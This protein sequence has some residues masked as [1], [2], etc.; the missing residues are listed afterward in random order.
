MAGAAVI[1]VYSGSPS[2]QPAAPPAPARRVVESSAPPSCTRCA[3]SKMP[4]TDR[5]NATPPNVRRARCSWSSR[6]RISTTAALTSSTGRISPGLPNRSR[7]TVLTKEPTGPPAP[8]QEPTAQIRPTAIRPSATPS[9][10]C[11]GSMSDAAAA[12]RP[13]ARTMLPMARATSRQSAATPRPTPRNARTTTDGPCGRALAGV[14]RAAVRARDAVPDDWFFE[15]TGR[16]TGLEPVDDVPRAAALA[17]IPAAGLVG[18]PVAADFRAAGLTGDEPFDRV[19]AAPDRVVP[20]ADRVLAAPDRVVPAPDRVVA[21]P[22]AG[23]PLEG[24][25][26]EAE[27]FPGMAVTL[28]ASVTSVPGFGTGARCRAPVDLSQVPVVGPALCSSLRSADGA[29]FPN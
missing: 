25:R 7:T 15:L 23:L 3:T 27:V 8:N 26:D 20:A 19:P 21:P 6:V 5:P 2:S 16:R 18:P 11:A 29:A 17:P 22:D 10:R 9:R 14:V 13:S 1:P 12:P 28:V 4:V 24:G